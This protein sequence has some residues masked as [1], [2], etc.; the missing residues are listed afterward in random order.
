MI[1]IFSYSIKN[2]DSF[3]HIH[4]ALDRHFDNYRNSNVHCMFILQ[5]L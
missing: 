3:V 2:R 1:A 5:M 4:V